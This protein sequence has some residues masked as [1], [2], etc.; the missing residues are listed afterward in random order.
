M[1]AALPPL[2]PPSWSVTRLEE[3][4]E[5][6]CQA[7]PRTA[8][9]VLPSLYAALVVHD[10][11]VTPREAVLTVLEQ[12]RP[13]R[14]VS[15]RYFEELCQQGRVVDALCWLRAQHPRLLRD[16]SY[17]ADLVPADWQHLPRVQARYQGLRHSV[18][19]WL[20]AWSH[21]V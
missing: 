21:F 4:W 2:P 1:A 10:Q 7:S 17:R 3:V 8:K 6:L 20:Q 19:R 9:F 18:R 16:A 11:V 15:R 12:T 14:R 5:K 13:R